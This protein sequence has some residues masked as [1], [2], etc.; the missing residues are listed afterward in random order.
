MS[1]TH[2]EAV[3]VAGKVL[4]QRLIDAVAN[5]V[6]VGLSQEH[7]QSRPPVVIHGLGRV[8]THHIGPRPDQRGRVGEIREAGRHDGLDRF[9]VEAMA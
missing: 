5:G 2:G 9:Q 7:H 1:E 6:V 8:E 3:D 4:A